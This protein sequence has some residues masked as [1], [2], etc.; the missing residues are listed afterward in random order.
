MV[1]SSDKARQLI[2]QANLGEFLLEIRTEKDLS[3][4]QVCKPVGP[5]GIS[6]NY[7]SE[8]ERGLKVPSDHIIREVAAVYG[9]DEAE[10]FYILDKVPLAAKEE[11]ERNKTLQ[12]VLNEV[13]K[14][15]LS[16]EQK[17]EVYEVMY[18]Y[19]KSITLIFGLVVV[20]PIFY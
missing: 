1:I 8:I 3:L 4:A 6:T 16:D 5:L 2:R 18:K 10:I 19:F 12:R 20:F 14:S 13:S 7:L 9:I 15:S 11:L 17:T